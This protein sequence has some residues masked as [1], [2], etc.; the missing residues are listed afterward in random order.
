MA[1]QE[2]VAEKSSQLQ[3]AELAEFRRRKRIEFEKNAL[4]YGDDE[5]SIRSKLAQILCAGRSVRQS[6]GGDMTAERALM[7]FASVTTKAVGIAL[8]HCA[9]VEDEHDVELTFEEASVALL[10]VSELL[11]AAPRLIDDFSC[12][13]LD[14]RSGGDT[15]HTDDDKEG[16]DEDEVES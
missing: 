15:R 6:E 16:D 3:G 11:D 7:R 5:N 9:M 10:G 4:D 13:K 14:L 8:A 2:T 12:A 1:T